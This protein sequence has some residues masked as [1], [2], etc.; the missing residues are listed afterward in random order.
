MNKESFEAKNEY[1]EDIKKAA[2]KYEVS[3]KIQYKV[4]YYAKELLHTKEGQDLR[5]FLETNMPAKK[6]TKD[7]A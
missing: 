6:V 5:E 7:G 4:K 1:V 3:K 2:K